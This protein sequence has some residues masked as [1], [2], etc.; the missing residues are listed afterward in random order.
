MEQT[1]FNIKNTETKSA[2]TSVYKM[3]GKPTLN[4]AD[5]TVRASAAAGSTE[6]NGFNILLG[7]P[8]GLGADK[9][10]QQFSI[11]K[12]ITSFKVSNHKDAAGNNDPGKFNSKQSFYLFTLFDNSAIPMFVPY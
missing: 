9:I 3:N 5:I 7:S 11:G 6:L 10:R 8:F 4:T 2:I 12:S 1:F